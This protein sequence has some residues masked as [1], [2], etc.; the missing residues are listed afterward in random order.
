MSKKGIIFGSILIAVI[1]FLF[2]KEPKKFI[3][4]VFSGILIII[5]LLNFVDIDTSSYLDH[6]LGRFSSFDNN[7]VGVS[8]RFGST[9][10]RIFLIKVGFLTFQDSPIFGH[11][12]ANFFLLNELHVYAHNNYIELLVDLGIVGTILFYSIYFYLIKSFFMLN[13]HV[14]IKI[15][16]ITFLTVLMVMDIAVVSYGMKLIIY[17][18]LFISIYLDNLKKEESQIDEK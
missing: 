17:T 15:F 1:L 4:I 10:G 7:M 5:V 13:K 6:I 8:D 11:G 2:L 12:I 9:G 16:I 18:L 14:P 3:T